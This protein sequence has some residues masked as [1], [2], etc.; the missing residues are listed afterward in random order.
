M[1]CKKFNKRLKL[2][3]DSEVPL[4]VKNSFEG[5]TLT[6]DDSGRNVS[7][8]NV[9]NFKPKFFSARMLLNYRYVFS[10]TLLISGTKKKRD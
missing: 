10:F 8:N 2:N 4:N 5:F 7:T 9:E 1:E 3:Q 6:I